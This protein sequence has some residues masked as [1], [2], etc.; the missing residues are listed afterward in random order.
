MAVIEAMAYRKPCVITPAADPQGMLQ[1]N[2]LAFHCKPEVGSI[3]DAISAAVN[4]PEEM[5]EDW[6]DRSR[7]MVESNFSWQGVAEKMVEA[8]RKHRSTK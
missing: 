4:S 8:Y 2:G 6:G 5:L 1:E 3:S 7:K